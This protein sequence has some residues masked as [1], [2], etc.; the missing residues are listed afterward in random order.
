MLPCMREVVLNVL[1]FALAIFIAAIPVAI[2]A[3]SY[4][5]YQ[6]EAYITNAEEKYEILRQVERKRITPFAVFMIDSK[7]RRYNYECY[8][9]NRY[10]PYE[11]ANV[12]G[13]YMIVNEYAAYMTFCYYN[14]TDIK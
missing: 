2:L 7:M 4:Y 12:K 14:C 13:G 5:Q 8:W 1:R 11:T 3:A 6:V 10:L 9:V